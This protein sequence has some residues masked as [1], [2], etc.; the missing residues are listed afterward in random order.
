MLTPSCSHLERIAG[1]LG[2]SLTADKKLLTQFRRTVLPCLVPL[3]PALDP[4]SQSLPESSEPCARRDRTLPTS[5]SPC[6]LFLFLILSRFPRE[7]SPRPAAWFRSRVLLN[8]VFPADGVRVGLPMS[9]SSRSNSGVSAGTSDESV[10]AGLDSAPGYKSSSTRFCGVVN[11][12]FRNAGAD[13]LR[14]S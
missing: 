2:W 5:L 6:S 10:M 3:A 11:A 8:N 4:P 13:G 9:S 14:G 12:G 1:A 7:I